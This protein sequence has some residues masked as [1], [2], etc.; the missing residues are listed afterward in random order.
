MDDVDTG[1]GK[2]E[3]EIFR[4]ADAREGQDRR[5]RRR[6]RFAPAARGSCKNGSRSP[7]SRPR[8]VIEVRGVE[9][10][11]HLPKTPAPSADAAGAKEDHDEEGDDGRRFDRTKT[12]EKAE[13][14]E[15]VSR[16]P[17]QTA[18]TGTAR[19]SAPL[20]TNDQQAPAAVRKLETGGGPHAAPAGRPHAASGPPPRRPPAG[21]P[22]PPGG[23]PRGPGTAMARA[24]FRWVAASYGCRRGLVSAGGR[25]PPLLLDLGLRRVGGRAAAWAEALAAAAR[26]AR[27]E[28]ARLVPAV[29]RGSARG[30]PASTARSAD[31]RIRRPLLASVSARG[32]AGAA[33]AALRWES[34]AF[35]LGFAGG[36]RTLGGGPAGG[37]SSGSAAG[38]RVVRRL[39]R[40]ARTRGQWPA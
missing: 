13:A 27:T 26:R 24:P 28:P 6:G 20:G 37:A 15:A 7:R 21:T 11:L 9:N 14:D 8:W 4:P 36:L 12:S 40:R 16:C 23:T 29:L 35:G 1:P 34:P 25:P 10:L 33:A 32:G 17:A 39:A 5:E 31:A 22:T 19:L 18:A 30:S 3:T 38:R 2:V